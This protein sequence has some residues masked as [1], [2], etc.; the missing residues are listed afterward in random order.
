MPNFKRNNKV[1][2]GMGAGRIMIFPAPI[3]ATRAP[4]T[5][6]IAEIGRTWIDTVGDAVFVLTSV[7][8][9]ASW[10]SSPASGATT[11]ASLIVT[12]NS[13]LQGNVDIGGTLDVVGTSTFGAVSI[14]GSFSYGGA[15]QINWTTSA[16]QAD[17]IILNATAGG[18]DITAGGAFDLDLT[19]AGGINIISNENAAN[20]IFIEAD[21]G[22]SETVVIHADQGTGVGSI[23]LTSDVGGIALTAGVA[24]AA[25]I[26]LQ[27]ASGGID[28]DG[29]LQI[30]IASSQNA[31][32]AIRMNASAGG[33][34]IDAAGAAGEDINIANAAGSIV[35]T[36]GESATN[37]IVIESTAGGIDILA[38]GA[39]AGEDIDITATG[40]SVNIS[41]TENAAGAIT[42]SCNGG[43]TETITVTN[44]QGTSA[45]SV[46]IDSVA[47]GVAITS[48]LDS[49]NSILIEADAGSSETVVIHADQ[50][51]GTAS[52]HMQSDVGGVTLTG[53]L[54]GDAI[55][56]SATS[57]SI[58]GTSGEDA[59]DSIYFRANAGSSETVRLHADQGTGT[60]SVHLQ[61][62]VGGVTLT[63]GLAGDSVN[64]VATS[65]S[66]VGTSG[67]DAADSIYLHADAGSSETVRLHSDQ[68]TGTA[69]VHLESDVG[70]ITLTG[71]LAGDAINFAA[72]NGSIT[73]TSGENAIDSIYFRA[74][75]GSSE[76]VRL[77]SDQGTSADSV[78][79][80]SDVGGITLQAVGLA[81]AD[82]INFESDAGG[83]DMDA[84][85][86]IN[87]ASSQAAATAIRI[88]ASNGAG[89]IDVDDGGGG[90]AFD[91]LAGISLDAAAAS[92]F[93]VAGAG[94]D[95]T[96]DS[97]SG[98]VIVNGEE[99]AANA[100]TLLSAAG[101]IDANAALQINIDS[102]QAAGTAI[103]IDASNAAG[104]LDIDSGTG[105]IAVDSTGA[106]SLDSA[107]ASNFTATGAFDVTLS[108]TA[109]SMLIDGGEAATD[110]VNIDASNA[111]GGIDMDSGTG[112]VAIDSSGAISIDGAAASNFNVTGAGI[113]ITVGSAAGR[114]IVDAGENAAQAIYLHLNAGTSETLDIHSDQ[115]TGDTSVNIRS[116]SG[117]ITLNSGTGAVLMTPQT[118]SVAGVSL[119]LN[120]RVGVATFTGQTTGAGSNEDF[121]ITNSSLGA[122]DGVFV[123]VSN[124][125]SN[126]ADMT[127]EGVITQTAGTLT[128]HT[129]NNGAAA[130]NGDVVITFWIIN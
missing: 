49:A 99:A 13:D 15:G 123:T 129:Q 68:G 78:N 105:G 22:V 77:H 37:S 29:A 92:N 20:A 59:A 50:G 38:S 98:R 115:G 33:I 118:G 58:T 42:I 30:N 62:D 10:S 104:G 110:A 102:S 4:T 120:A 124:L 16:A 76:T 43:T 81:S 84:V 5:S 32:D 18:V 54:A 36:A 24:N 27:C 127:L 103:V 39:A 122:G 87:I 6:D 65:G 48:G 73:G 21:G 117:G 80:L 12:G 26:A 116:D 108:S 52:V 44:S 100:I 23:A 63:G 40:S 45:S 119:T 91:S 79:L 106:I 75:A 109:G 107:A 126:D 67:E 89:G 57:G 69:S 1:G 101:G 47:G 85:L 125:G 14:S 96:L 25:A 82:A 41:A 60:A 97:G 83:I 31:A 46:A 128:V 66:I 28:M 8:G 9:T 51:T 11:L 71:G 112:G 17:A 64:F 35:L 88:D 61:S 113:D 90:M 2:Y 70:G 74:N 34:D 121:T 93:T 56:F 53:G 111:A 19:S 114:I 130:L 86:Q 72:T 3:V 95:L 55:N 7:A 94:I